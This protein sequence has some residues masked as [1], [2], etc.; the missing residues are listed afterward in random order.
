MLSLLRRCMRRDER[1]RLR[2][3]GDAR[4]LIEEALAGDTDEPDADDAALIRSYIAR[5]S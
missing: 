5:L 3:I 4:I 2:D 1:Q